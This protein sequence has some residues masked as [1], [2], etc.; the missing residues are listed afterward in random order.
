MDRNYEILISKINEFRRKFYLNQLLRGVI[1][2]LALLLSLYLF[3][4]VLVYYIRPAPN[5]KTILFFAYLLLLSVSTAAGIIKPILAYLSLSKI[6][7]LE[8]SAALI[9]NHFE[10][11]RDKL[12]NTLQLKA[13]A[14]LAPSQNQLILAGIDQKIDEL[15]PIPFSKAISFNDN[16]KYVKYFL[17]PLAL[18][19]LIAVTAPVVWEEGTR[20]LIH[21]NKE[22]LPAAPFNFVLRNPGM[23]VTQGDDL[24]IELELKGDQLPQEVYLQEG[25]NTYKLERK[26]NSRFIHSF[27]N[28]QQSLS[29]R[30]SA[31]GFDSKAWLLTVKPRPSILNIQASLVYPS[32]LKKKNETIAN[33]GDLVLPEGTTVTWKIYTENAAMLLFT[34]GGKTR[35]LSFSGN[36]TS[37]QASLKKSQDY[38][39]VPKNNFS[40]H[41]DSVTHKI[42]VIPDLP[43][44]ISMTET[45][46]SLSSKAHYFTGNI[47]D[48]HGF[49]LLKFVYVL[50]EDNRE[51]KKVSTA[52]PIHTAQQENAFLYYWNLKKLSIKPGQM[53]EYY[54]E[55]ADNDGVNGPKITRSA[56][57]TY[58]PPSDQELAKQQN[59]ESGNLK[60]QMNSAIRLAAEVERGSK[61]LGENLLDKKDLSFEDRKE[62]NQL[63]DKQK[64]LEDVVKEIQQ[65]KQ[66]SSN[67]QSDE[68]QSK[69]AIA[70]KQKQIDDLFKN[71]LDPK[72]KA[73]LEKLQS[74]MD[75][76]NK[77]QVQNELSK[78]TM[79]NKS[80]KNE[81]DRVL[82]L[83]K[84]LEFEQNL[85]S[86]VERLKKLADSQKEL[87]K[88]AQEKN[89]EPSALKKQQDKA[90]QEFNDLKKDIR[91]LDQKNKAL[92]RPN[93]FQPM[94]KESQFVQELQQQSLENLEKQQQQ[95]AAEN[96]KK[97]AEEMQKMAEKMEES[98]Q[99]AAEMENNLNTEE[100]RRLLQN[101]LKTSFDQEKVVLSFKNIITSDPSYTKNVQ[102]QREI[103]DNMKTIADSLYS[104][105]KRVPQ[106][107]ST[108]SGEM[109]KINFNIN[110]SLESL[111]ERRTAE[112]V[113]NQQYTMTS[114]NN[115]SLML[116]EALEQLEKNKKNAKSGGKGKGKQSMQQLQKMQEQLN[117]SME[118][119]KQQLEKEGNKGSVPKGK[120]SEGFA[121][122]AQQ[123]QMIREAL[124][125]INTE[126][127][128]DGKSGLGNLNQLV[129]EM[130]M[131]ESDLINKRI[132]EE[133]IKRQKS[134]TTKLL[135]AEK[136][137]RD[138][139]KEG[140]RE[141][142][143]GG[144][145]PPSYPKLLEEFK[146]SNLSE[147]EFLQKLPPTLNYY[148]KNKITAYFK[149]LNLPK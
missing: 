25:L 10:P 60:K 78:M 87:G 46:D 52:I 33:A 76:N 74:L 94:E 130:K 58:T 137:S 128:K 68:E 126:E 28:L 61:K 49:S 20:S 32:Y 83:Y 50:K 89:A 17:V 48:D 24:L 118:Q 38:Q 144:D 105:S 109:Q 7:S 51:K 129:K 86:Q 3:L 103:K 99:S 53:I 31:G 133:T 4:F 108:V 149:S 18:I 143:A 136:A 66:K 39:I 115:L 63:L 6:L 120:M 42:D 26:G 93:S 84:Q 72:T 116:N 2:T 23:T 30:F 37:Y 34:L 70:D 101:I 11:I 100:L 29:F 140:K 112:A 59:A 69:M 47:T 56:I 106:I 132:E 35:Q 131:T 123:Q 85:Q 22:I 90:A 5:I 96:Q 65:A 125:K 91:Q 104:L 98:N 15:K 19:V 43:P 8:E 135:D 121:K 75:Q 9:G 40:A 57:K 117:K 79:D 124:Q 139:D 114:I 110:K 127:N 41:P 12:L 73:L 134:I 81:L 13:L 148:Y 21:Y 145:Y 88:K 142:K 55:V 95:K 82:E 138:Q 1:Y 54:L 119:A 44:S 97:A 146:K 36:E 27:K 62:I 80:L 92:E 64:K 147:K 122:M 67:E 111:G 16:K 113:R 71:V 102:Q 77:D 141:S 107:E 45:I 14:D